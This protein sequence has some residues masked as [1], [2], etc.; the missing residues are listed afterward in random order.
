MN[1]CNLSSVLIVMEYHCADCW[2]WTWCIIRDVLVVWGLVR[3]EPF[4]WDLKIAWRGAVRWPVNLLGGCWEN[5]KPQSCQSVGC[6]STFP[7][8]SVAT[9]TGKLSKAKPWC[10]RTLTKWFL[11]L[12]PIKQSA[13]CCEDR[14]T[15]NSTE[16]NVSSVTGRVSV[17]W[18]FT[19]RPRQ[20]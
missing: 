18:C 2:W 11:F 7:V 16:A 13:Q 8:I 14:K 5:H 1:N 17:S 9:Q 4:D 19:S 15:E 10:F 3:L 6:S 20:L 12:N